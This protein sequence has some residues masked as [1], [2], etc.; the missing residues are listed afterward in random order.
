MM[1]SFP[2]SATAAPQAAFMAPAYRPTRSCPCITSARFNLGVGI[3]SAARSIIR[4]M[5]VSGVPM[6]CMLVSRAPIQW[7][8]LIISGAA[9]PGKKYLLPPENPI[10]SWGKTGPQTTSRS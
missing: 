6:V 2:D 10:T 7:V 5:G 3:I 9:M 4:R 1:S 8:T